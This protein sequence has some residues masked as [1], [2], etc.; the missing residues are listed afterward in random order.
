MRA[1]LR[2]TLFLVLFPLLL[3]SCNGDKPGAPN[4]TI[5]LQPQVLELLIGE[6]G[7]LTVKLSRSGGFAGAVTVT[8]AGETTGLAY[9]PITISDTE[10][11][12]TLTI[13]AQDGATIGT[14]FPV[15]KA[16]G[17]GLERLETLTLRLSVPKA[18]VTSVSIEDNEGSKQV[19]QGAGSVNLSVT[20]RHLER[21]TGI[22]LGELA[23]A[24]TAS[25]DGTTLMVSAAIPHGAPLGNKTLMLTTAG[26]TTTVPEA[27]VVTPITAGP[28]G[29]DVV[30]QG[31]PQRPYR[32]LKTALA[33]WREGDTVYLQNGLYSAASGEQWPSQSGTPPTVLPGPNVPAGAVIMGESATEVVLEGSGGGSAG[34]AFAGDASVSNL[35]LRG[36]ARAVLANT[37]TVTLEAIRVLESGD[38]LFAY[39]NVTL[40]GNASEL[41]ANTNGLVSSA[42]AVVTLEETAVYDN[43]EA[44][45]ILNQA[46]SVTLRRVQLH[47][48]QTGIRAS[49]DAALTIENSAIFNHTDS[50]LRAE[51][52]ARVRLQA[53]EVHNNTRFG[54]VFSG[55][56]LTLRGTKVY[57]NLEGGAGVYIE[58]DPSKVDLGTLSEPGL[59][60]IYDNLGVQLLDARPDRQ[61]PNLV[62]ITLSETRLNGLLLEPGV[63]LAEGTPY[64]NVPYFAILGVNNGIRVY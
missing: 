50:G 23:V 39:G 55:A 24:F 2:T 49:G 8:L 16:T 40:S 35:T 22:T 13:V 30:G 33:V 42:G 44:G 34:L 21:V 9:D 64:F 41:A 57:A 7:S 61:E 43:A 11:E 46:P 28:A 54:L 36:F 19:R 45:I 14:S 31:T 62:F 5:T 51:G 12:G 1:Y 48:N 37:G 47:R 25:E 56:E 4:F 10:S 38:G 26:G 59:N 53:S 58:G 52:N 27:L 63:Y 6:P 17:G 15:V 3:A 60:E 20:G 18:E 29:D 32:S